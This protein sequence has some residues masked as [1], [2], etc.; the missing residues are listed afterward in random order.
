MRNSG[1]RASEIGRRPLL[2]RRPARVLIDDFH[3]IRHP[4]AP[5][6]VCLGVRPQDPSNGTERTGSPVSGL[7][8]HDF[9]MVSPC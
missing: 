2:A 8:I 9:R 1:A 4:T 6:S 7:R 5:R 3:R